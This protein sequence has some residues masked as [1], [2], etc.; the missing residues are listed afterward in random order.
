MEFVDRVDAGQ[1]IPTTRRTYV[2]AGTIGA[3]LAGAVF[4][5]VL[6]SG[7]ASLLQRPPAAGDFFDV[8][9]HSLLNLHWSVPR[10]SLVVEGFLVHG[11]VYE[12]FGPLPAL[13]RL[14]IAAITD[15]FDGRLGQLSLL[16]AF[17]IAMTFTVRLAVRLRP[18]VRGSEPVSRG[19]QWAVGGFVFV[20]G[21]GS[22]F[23][24]LASRAWA[25]H[26]AELWGAALALGAFEFVLAYTLAPTRK[27]LVVASALT[28]AALLSRGSVGVGPLVALGLV[29]VAS[30]WSRTR[31]FAGLVDVAARRARLIPLFIAVLI[32]LALYA[33]VNYSKFGTLF[34]LPFQHQLSND[35]FKDNRRVL[36]ANGGSMFNSGLV[37]TTAW[38]Y[39]GV[40]PPRVFALFPWVT[41]GARTSIIGNHVVAWTWTESFPVTMPLLSVL[42]LVGFVGVVRPR[43]STPSLA[44]LRAPVIGAIFAT[45]PTLSYAYVAQRYLSDFMPLGVLLALSGLHVVLRWSSARP[46]RQLRSVVWAGLGLLAVVSVWFN[47]GLGVIYG[48][49][50]DGTVRD[51]DIAAFVAFQYDLHRRFPGGAPPDVITGSRLPSPQQQ[52]VFVLGNCKALYWSEGDTWTALEGTEAIG[53]FRLRV[54]FPATPTGW[55]PLV[56]SNPV[57]GRAQFLA[58]RVLPGNRAQFAYDAVF[59]EPPITIHAGRTQRVDVL[60][61]AR[62]RSRTGGDVRVDLDDR[63]AYS[64]T[65]PNAIIGERLR[66]LADVTV[67]HAD[68]PDVARRFSGAIERLPADMSLCRKITRG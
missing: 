30:L 35:I 32:P 20:V 38:Q 8:Q 48:R 15:S 14:P 10:R 33:Y 64:T 68:I 29:V 37:P 18:L 39:L 1:E 51:H 34:S 17:A 50:L 44:A 57:K 19:E 56:V 7:H 63:R 43:R 6:L 53:R 36:A 65:L 11:K 61:D 46:R 16:L 52:R 66:P 42:G 3:V 26:E 23:A 54:R 4:V 25:Y 67:G 2:V 40:K 12:Y 47:V 27:H 49:L 22:V 5:V 59:P 21:A 62:H 13:L 24:F 45:I 31:R 41:F 55:E 58:V 28:T 60:M 9:A